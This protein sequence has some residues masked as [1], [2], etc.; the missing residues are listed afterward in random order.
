MAAPQSWPSSTTSRAPE[1]SIRPLTS[2]RLEILRSTDYEELVEGG[3]MFDNVDD[4]I[5]TSN[6]GYVVRWMI[7]DNDNPANTKT[8]IVRTVSERDVAGRDKEVTLTT[9]RTLD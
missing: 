5:D 8:I 1:A 3:S 2:E 4:Y 9:L 7:V 6:D